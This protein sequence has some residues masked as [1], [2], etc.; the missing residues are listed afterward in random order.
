MDEDRAMT[1][2]QWNK[3]M[4]SMYDKEMLKAWEN[5][6]EKTPKELNIIMRNQYL[7]RSVNHA[8]GMPVNRFA[9]MAQYANR[10]VAPKNQTA[11]Q[12]MY[13]NVRLYMFSWITAVVGWFLQ[14]FM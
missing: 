14:W 2:E 11:W 1:K 7:M 8:L 3:L 4:D 10:I 13:W 9:I 6:A 12:K 5:I